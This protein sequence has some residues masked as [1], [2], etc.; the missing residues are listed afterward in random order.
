MPGS[1]PAATTAPGEGGLFGFG[2]RNLTMD[3]EECTTLYIYGDGL[4][5][6]SPFYV[7]REWAIALLK[8]IVFSA[9]AGIAIAAVWK[10]VPLGLKAWWSWLRA[11]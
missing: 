10:I 1:P 11:E 3:S 8:I 9:A 5:Y 4:M 7:S 6:A 2:P